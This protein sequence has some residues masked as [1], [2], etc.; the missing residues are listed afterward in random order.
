MVSRLYVRSYDECAVECPGGAKLLLRGIGIINVQDLFGMASVRER[1]VVDLVIELE[2]WNEGESYD[3]L[4]LDES[5]HEILGTA[6]PFIRMP[7]ALGRNV[8]ILVEIAARNQLLKQQ[9][10]HSAQR[11]VQ[12]VDSDLRRPDAE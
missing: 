7:V 11:F 4:G 6:I 1:K 2:H 5:T 8:S 12:A 3:R 10:H 9:G